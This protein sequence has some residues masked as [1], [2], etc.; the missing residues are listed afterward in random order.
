MKA[1]RSLF[2]VLALLVGLVVVSQGAL[3][4]GNAQAYQDAYDSCMQNKP[5]NANACYDHSCAFRG[6]VAQ[7]STVVMGG[8]V[9]VQD[10]SAA[11]TAAQTTCAPHQQAF[12]RCI[13]QHGILKQPLSPPPAAPSPPAQGTAA[14]TCA[15]GDNDEGGC[16][17]FLG[18]HSYSFEP[19]KVESATVV[20]DTGRGPYCQSTV[21][22]EVKTG[23]D[24]W[25]RVGEFTVMSGNGADEL[26]PR[27][28]TVVIGDTISALKIHD[29]CVCCID[30][31][32]VTL[33]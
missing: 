15:N 9:E 18:E 32:Q 19:R 24:T 5:A 28:R 6:C 13:Q 3:A 16:C 10:P 11:V 33:H 8:A 22:V 30:D 20:F 7:H 31:S 14:L 23:P 1:F 27:T 26:A 21:D 17:C 12:S 2:A 4:Q 29:G 25:R